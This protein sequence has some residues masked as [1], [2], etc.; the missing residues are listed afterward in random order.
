MKRLFA[1][2]LL[3][4]VS[5][6][7]RAVPNLELKET[8]PLKPLKYC[9]AADGN[10]TAQNEDCPFGTTEVSSITTSDGTGKAVHAPLGTTMDSAAAPAPQAAPTAQTATPSA[11]TPSESPSDKEVMRKGRKSLL[12]AFIFGLVGAVALRLMGRSLILGFFLGVVLEIV[13]VAAA[14]IAP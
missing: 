2:V 8:P 5:L 3:L 9:K 7:A 14:V 11:A 10:V 12:K 4:A 13:L 1:L 6:F